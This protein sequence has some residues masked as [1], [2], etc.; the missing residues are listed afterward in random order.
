M[1]ETQTSHALFG[2]CASLTTLVPLHNI[3]GGL[4]IDVADL[5]FASFVDYAPK[6]GFVMSS[7]YDFSEPL[8]FPPGFFNPTVDLNFTYRFV[9]DDG[10][11]SLDTT[12]NTETTS[13]ADLYCMQ[14]LLDGVFRFSVPEGAKLGALEGPD[15][16]FKGGQYQP[17]T[18]QADA[19]GNPCTLSDNG[20]LPQG[21]FQPCRPTD[22]VDMS[23]PG[24]WPAQESLGMLLGGGPVDPDNWHD[25]GFCSFIEAPLRIA[26]ASGT[27]NYPGNPD[28]KV[29]ADTV[30][31]PLN[32]DATKYHNVRCNF[33]PRY[34]Q[35]SIPSID[36]FTTA[37]PFGINQK[38]ITTGPPVCEV[39]V[40]AKRLNVFPDKV[41]AVFFDGPDPQHVPSYEFH[42]EAFALYLGLQAYSPGSVAQM[43]NRTPETNSGTNVDLRPFAHVLL[44]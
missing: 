32:G 24:T 6:G 8:P 38:A 14:C 23:D 21:C 20:P 30:F 36:P 37:L 44:H 27:N 3:A 39:A 22:T 42:N 18:N 12:V 35:G 17:M 9:L 16:T 10:V 25:T 1:L 15:G 33:H 5:G 34:E 7:E 28:P 2:S 11:A 29:L 19:N 40:R 41:E 43:C 26:I 13:G 31:E 4:G